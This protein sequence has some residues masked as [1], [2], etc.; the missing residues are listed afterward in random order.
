VHLLATPLHL[1]GGGLLRV[2]QQLRLV[3][4]RGHAA[5]RA[6]LRIRQFARGKSARD[7]RQVEQRRRDAHLLARG[8]DHDAALHVQPLGAVVELVGLP[9]LADV[10][11]AHQLEKRIL[12]GVD[13][14]RVGD[15]L[16][17][18]FIERA[19]GQLEQRGHRKLLFAAAR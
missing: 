1:L 8:A 4:R 5:Q 18:E 2:L 13:A 7:A 12:R 17:L 14:L 19:A 15:E 6:N 10:E 9:A 3:L 16:F 11:L